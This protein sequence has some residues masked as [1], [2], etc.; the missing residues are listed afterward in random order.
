MNNYLLGFPNKKERDDFFI[1]IVVI[2]FFISLFWYF[3]G[4]GNG[5]KLNGNI[6]PTAQV[7][8]DID[9]DMDGIIDAKDKCPN[10][11]GVAANAG[12]PAD[13][14]NDGI[15]DKVDKCPKLAGISGNRGCPADTDGDGIYDMNDKCPKVAFKSATGCPPVTDGD[16]VF[17]HFDECPNKKGTKEN[18]GC[19]FS[20]T[21]AAAIRNIQSSVEFETG[22][23]ILTKASTLKLDEL[24][25]LLKRYPDVKM[26]I[27]GYTDSAGDDAKNMKLSESRAL[28]CKTYLVDKGLPSSKLKSKGFGELRPVASN[29]NPKGRAKNRR[30]E[31]KSF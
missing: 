11:A 14:D 5:P 18:N 8:E 7:I 6:I 1:A 22:R 9:S 21:D 15:Y 25:K 23:A 10:M 27:E 3:L 30:V 19:P 2:L 16:G 17:D 12:C 28:A 24:A 4:S 26:N 31:F 20:P 29:A 13:S